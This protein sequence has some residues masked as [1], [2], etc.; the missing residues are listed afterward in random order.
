MAENRKHKYNDR[1]CEELGWVCIPLVVETYGCWGAAEVAAF[2][3]LACRLSTRLNQ[4][5]SIQLPRPSL[6]ESQLQSHSVQVNLTVRPGPVQLKVPL[7]LRFPRFCAFSSF[8]GLI[9]Y[10]FMYSCCIWDSFR[11]NCP[12]DIL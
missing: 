12:T 8:T 1:K 7:F 4:P 6:S 5:K 11:E 10:T 3:K 2:S 9:M